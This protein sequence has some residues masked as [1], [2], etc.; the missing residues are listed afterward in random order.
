MTRQMTRQKCDNDDFFAIFY[1]LPD[2]SL[3]SDNNRI[4]L[5]FLGD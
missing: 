4:N 1:N 3:E 5:P 2:H